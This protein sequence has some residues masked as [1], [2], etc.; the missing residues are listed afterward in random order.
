MCRSVFPRPEDVDLEVSESTAA[1]ADKQS[2][3]RAGSATAAAN[4]MSCRD[5]SESW[6][7]SRHRDEAR[8]EVT[9]A[10]VIEAILLPE[11]S[12]DELVVGESKETRTGFHCLPLYLEKA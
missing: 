4:G 11:M 1:M 3:S 7:E 12:K 9:G 6:K 8:Q 2:S 5:L 10:S